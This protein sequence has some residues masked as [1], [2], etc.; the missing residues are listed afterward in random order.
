MTAS[1]SGLEV[2]QRRM[3]RKKEAFQYAAYIAS[4]A[5][6]ISQINALLLATK[7]MAANSTGR[8]LIE[9]LISEILI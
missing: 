2:K 6:I 5:A 9:I 8:L 3:R 1:V 7:R 4:A